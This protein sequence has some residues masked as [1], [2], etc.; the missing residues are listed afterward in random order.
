MKL[1]NILIAH[2][3]S[4]TK[5]VEIIYVQLQLHNLKTKIIYLI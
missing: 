3:F 2:L 5:L 4:I 1:T